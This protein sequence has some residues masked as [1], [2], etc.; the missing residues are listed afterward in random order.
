MSSPVCCAARTFWAGRL[1]RRRGRIGRRA[2]IPAPLSWEDAQP[3][4][5][6]GVLRQPVSPWRIKLG[7]SGSS[8]PPTTQRFY[9][10]SP[11]R[12]DKPGAPL[13]VKVEVDGR[14][15]A[16]ASRF[17]GRDGF[18]Y[19]PFLGDYAAAGVRRGRRACRVERAARGLCNGSPISL[20]LDTDCRIVKSANDTI[21]MRCLSCFTTGR[22]R[23]H[24]SPSFARHPRLSRSRSN[25]AGRSTSPGER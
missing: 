23:T 20:R 22:R 16:T 2:P 4:P 3:P 15:R 10:L 7:V 13:R 17:A 11:P 5:P 21:P 9:L 25:K 18:Q 19:P 14:E 1:G 8:L 6:A 12:L 24:Q